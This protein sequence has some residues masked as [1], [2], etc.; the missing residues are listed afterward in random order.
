MDTHAVNLLGLSSN[1]SAKLYFIC[2]PAFIA[3]NFPINEDFWENIC[4]NGKISFLFLKDECFNE[5]NVMP[6]FLTVRLP[7][8]NAAKIAKIVNLWTLW[9]VIQPISHLFKIRQKTFLPKAAPLTSMEHLAK[10]L[11]VRFW[12][13]E[14]QAKTSRGCRFFAILPS[15]LWGNLNI[16]LVW[17]AFT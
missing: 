4:T 6:L 8:R 9:R 14:L 2:I 15:L 10:R 5:N 12:K 7:H 11:F 3:S 13:D 17:F 16:T 1:F